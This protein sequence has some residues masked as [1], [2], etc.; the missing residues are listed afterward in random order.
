MIRQIV[1][2]MGGEFMEG[3]VSG[4]TILLANDVMCAKYQV[5]LRWGLEDDFFFLA[6]D[7]GKDSC[8][9]FEV[10]I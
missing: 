8:G 1:R 2:Y 5:G 9:V 7:R 6:C 10:D 4:N 3:L